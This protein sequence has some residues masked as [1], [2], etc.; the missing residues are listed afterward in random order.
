M[1]PVLKSEDSCRIGNPCCNT[2]M[3][4]WACCQ[5]GYKYMYLSPFWRSPTAFGHFMS[6]HEHSI[7]PVLVAVCSLFGLVSDRFTASCWEQVD[8][9]KVKGNT[10]RNWAFNIEVGCTSSF[11]SL[12][13]ARYFLYSHSSTK[14]AHLWLRSGSALSLETHL[15]FKWKF[16][17]MPRKSVYSQL[18][19]QC[20]VQESKND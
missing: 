11:S 10:V 9:C 14:Y 12:N 20:L 2:C 6:W 5:H 16:T 13:W 8:F 1:S 17:L 18:Q 15:R 7:V 19:E 3:L 4:D